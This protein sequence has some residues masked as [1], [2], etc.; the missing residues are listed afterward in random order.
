MLHTITMIAVLLDAYYSES[1]TWPL[2]RVLSGAR[3]KQ[4]R[5]A[6]LLCSLVKFGNTMA[7]PPLMAEQHESTA[8]P[9]NTTPLV[10]CTIEAKVS[11]T[12]HKDMSLTEG[13]ATIEPTRFS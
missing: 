12:A 8:E 1:W 7:V 4:H 11:T 3:P 5:C 9:N 2:D 6:S 10:A 13:T